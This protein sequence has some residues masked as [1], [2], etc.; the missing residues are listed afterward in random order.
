MPKVRGGRGRRR[1]IGVRKG[2]SLLAAANGHAAVEL[3]AR[4]KE[5]SEQRPGVYRM[6]GPNGDLL[7]V[8]KSVNLRTRLLSYFRADR[9]EKA[10]DIISV[11]RHIEWEYVPS[12][13]AAL[14]L[15]LRLI[16]RYRPRFNFQYK[17]DGATCFIKVTRE[18][19]P[20][21]L[22]ATQVLDDGATYYGPFRVH[23]LVRNLLREVG[24]LLELRDC[25]TGM[26]MRF[27]DQ[28]DLFS[29][30]ATPRCVRA[31]LHKC[32]AP[33]AGRCT[34]A[35]YSAR[36]AEAR[37][38][39]EGNVHRPLRVLQDRMHV[40]AERMQF[41]Y[42]AQL[43]DRALRLEDARSELVALRGTLEALTFIYS[44]PGYG[45]DD[46]VYLIRRGSVRRELPAPRSA[47]EEQALL[48]DARALFKRRERVLTTIDPDTADDILLVSKWFRSRPDELTRTLTPERLTA[49][50]GGGLTAGGGGGLTAA[51]GGG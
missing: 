22:L 2:E 20:R 9:G 24:D 27:A 51:E 8:G 23:E 35:E 46:R 49:G 45:G 36:V 48:A 50:G 19:A 47:A 33:C 41:E 12:E 1:P 34:R 42:A 10:T 5:H 11:T 26:P 44:V 38:F 40:A 28:I 4:V 37:R 16:K 7:Y 14:L 30:Q 6:L 25:R 15:E 39:L 17:F 31:D 43:R 13:F 3:R 29:F 21:V 32:L 18:I